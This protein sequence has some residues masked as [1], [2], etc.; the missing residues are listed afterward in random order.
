MMPISGADFR[1]SSSVLPTRAGD[2]EPEI[3]FSL[4]E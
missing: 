3:Q 1:F 4:D 2:A